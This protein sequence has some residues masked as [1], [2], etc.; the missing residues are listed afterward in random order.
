VQASATEPSS[1]HRRLLIVDDLQ[2]T[3][4]SLAALMRIKG[5]EVHTAYDGETAVEMAASA[6]PE[7]IVLDIGLPKMNGYEVCRAVRELP[8]GDAIFIV[9]LT[10]WGQPSD[11]QRTEDAGFDWHLV[12]PV[13][14]EALANLL[15]QL[16]TLTQLRATEDSR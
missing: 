1:N 8:N 3:A 5:H 4:D 9:A 15:L 11:R 7:V 13:D 6:R 10:G 2:D 14:G 12:K 16:P